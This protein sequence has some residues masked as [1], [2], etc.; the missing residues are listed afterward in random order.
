MLDFL[1]NQQRGMPVGLTEVAEAIGAHKSTVLRLLAPLVESGLVQKTGRSDYA[2]GPTT[3]RWGQAYL[4]GLDLRSAARPV[5]LRLASLTQETIHLV[6]Y[7]PP[8]VVYVEKIDSPRAVRMHS[9]V[10]DRQPIY[11]TAVG[12]AYLAR[13]PSGSLTQSVGASLL[14]RTPHTITDLAA[15][16]REVGQ[17]AARGFAIDDQE[18][19]LEIRCVGAAILDDKG[20]P[21]AGVSVSAPASRL[22]LSK[23][24]ELGQLVTHAA[25]VL[26]AILGNPEALRIQPHASGTGEDGQDQEPSGFGV[27]AFEN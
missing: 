10:G 15:L 21:V 2:L 18:N 9:R 7:D 25:T 8:D 23:A 20:D 11:C 1:A 13:L 4:G 26:S 14:G 6:V 27:S 17:V 19:E 24:K 16:E 22:T 5:L 3:I 12:K